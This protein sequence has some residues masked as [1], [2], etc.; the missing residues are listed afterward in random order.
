MNK[1]IIDFI[2]GE[3]ENPDN[4]PVDVAENSNRALYIMLRDGYLT[5]ERYEQLKQHVENTL[6]LLKEMEQCQQSI[7]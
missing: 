6:H 5:R 7:Q 2:N 4:N 1:D 3:F